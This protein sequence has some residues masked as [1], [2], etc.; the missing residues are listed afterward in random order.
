MVFEQNTSY[1]DRAISVLGLFV[2]QTGFFLSSTKRNAIP[3]PTVVVGLFGFFLIPD[4]PNRRNPLAFWFTKADA[5]LA[6]ER[7]ERHNRAE[8]KRMDLKAIK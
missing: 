6:M 1:G 5:A 7:L 4:Y 8:P 3:W 2:F